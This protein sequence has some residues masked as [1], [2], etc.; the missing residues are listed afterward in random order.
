MTAVLFP[1]QGI[2]PVPWARD[3]L[4]DT[5]LIDTDFTDTGLLDT[6]E[7]ATHVDLRR[8]LRRNDRVLLRADVRQALIVAVSLSAHA[9][10]A[11][12]LTN[13]VCVGHSLG[14]LSAWAAM[15]AFDAHDAVRLAAARGS[16]MALAAE[17]MPGDLVVV[18]SRQAV[19]AGVESGLAL[20]AHNAPDEWVLTG[21][22]AAIERVVASGGRRLRVGGPWHHPHMARARPAFERAL[23]RVHMDPRLGADARSSLSAQLTRPVQWVATMR[24][25]ETHALFVTVGPGR[26]LRA[27]LHRT[28]RHANVLGTDHGTDLE[29]TVGILV[30]L[31]D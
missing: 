23:E 11:A 6:V 2:D 9:R 4:E 15:G 5:G 21:E 24:R 18:R 27:L 3:L 28:L 31:V 26:T 17:E 16:A 13:V 14:A 8:A 19:D 30:G 10:L 29:R 1:G 22:L 25:L 20:A 12:L 7:D